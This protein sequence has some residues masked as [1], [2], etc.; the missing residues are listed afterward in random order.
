MRVNGLSL[1]QGKFRLGIRKYFFP[2]RVAHHW[3]RLLR[4][5]VESLPW[6]CLK[7]CLG[8]LHLVV[9]WAGLMVGFLQVFS[10]NRTMWISRCSLNCSLITACLD[11]SAHIIQLDISLKIKLVFDERQC[12]STEV[13]MVGPVITDSAAP[14]RHWHFIFLPY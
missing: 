2:E 14:F 12:F 9:D 13:E 1:Y 6:S 8:T 7:R 11:R 10:S 3:N 5:V 4:Q